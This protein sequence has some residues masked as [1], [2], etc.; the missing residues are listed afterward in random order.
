MGWIW[1]GYSQS[2]LFLV[3]Q[4]KVRR[5]EG[6]KVGAVPVQSTTTI[7]PASVITSSLIGHYSRCL[8]LSHGPQ[9]SWI[10]QSNVPLTAMSSSR[11][12]QSFWFLIFVHTVLILTFAA[13]AATAMRGASVSTVTKATSRA[14][15]QVVLHWFRHGDLRLLDNPALIHSR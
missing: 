7:T 15:S 12:K 2:Y 5:S 1:N 6:R 11:S 13:G 8:S 14:S 3:K 4:S 10:P 9:S